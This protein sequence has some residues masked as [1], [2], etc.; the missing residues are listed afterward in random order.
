MSKQISRTVGNQPAAKAITLEQLRQYFHLPIVQ[1]SNELGIC[2]TL[3]KKICRK[4]KIHRW[5]YRQV[6]AMLHLSQ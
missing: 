2:T 6:S 4:H 1:V 3:L 5:P